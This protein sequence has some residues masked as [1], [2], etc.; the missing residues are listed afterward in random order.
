MQVL[1]LDYTRTEDDLDQHYLLA[2]LNLGLD[3][4]QDPKSTIE[5]LTA[6]IT[7]LDV[8]S[9]R[10]IADSLQSLHSGS[11]HQRSGNSSEEEPSSAKAS[12]QTTRSIPSAP[13]S[14]KS[15]SSRKYPYVKIRKGLRRLSTLARRRPSPTSFSDPVLSVPAVK[16]FTVQPDNV[17][18]PVERVLPMRSLSVSGKSSIP[19]LASLP[20]ARPHTVYVP[21]NTPVPKVKDDD[22]LIAARLRSLT[23]SRLQGLRAQQLDERGRFVRFETEQRSLMVSKKAYM[24]RIILQNYKDQEQAL[25]NSHSQAWPALENRHLAAEVELVRT[26]EMERKACD[27]RL[28]HMEGYCQA[29]TTL[30]GAPRRHVTEKDYRKLEQQYHVRGGMDNLHEARINVLREKQAKQLERIAVKQEQELVAASMEMNRRLEDLEYEFSIE[31]HELQDEFTERKRRIL[32]RWKL[33]E[34]IERRKIENESG[35][36]YGPLP[37]IV[38]PD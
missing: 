38:W 22:D 11:T 21:H 25:Y 30:K 16:T 33:M 37:D 7:D 28:K 12:S 34:A 15:S 4:P 1:N 23:N 14:V 35:E 17:S 27:T 20:K 6:N 2:A 9:P 29:R 24:R 26:L 31:E 3:I 10:P 18:V 8:S 36:E 13:P 19:S 32:S 5:I